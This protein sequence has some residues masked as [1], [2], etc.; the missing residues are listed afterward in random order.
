MLLSTCTCLILTAL[1]Q[2]VVSSVWTEHR[3][4]TSSL[5]FINSST[6]LVVPR[7]SEVLDPERQLRRHCRY[8]SRQ[9]V[10]SQNKVI[11]SMQS[12]IINGAPP[13]VWAIPASET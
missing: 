6:L 1:A 2:E 8:M 11:W 4:Y 12:V 5:H 7:C 13:L 10:I 3:K 9:A